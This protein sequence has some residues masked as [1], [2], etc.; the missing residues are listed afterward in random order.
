MYANVPVWQ[1][2]ASG[3]RNL[4]IYIYNIYIY[5]YINGDRVP[6]SKRGLIL[7]HGGPLGLGE[8]IGRPRLMFPII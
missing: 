7:L 3:P 8:L 2:E 1:T 4:V 6:G 5:I